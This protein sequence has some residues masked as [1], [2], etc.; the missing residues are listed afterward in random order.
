MSFT[1][2][3]Y[4]ILGFFYIVIIVIANYAISA[5]AQ[6]QENAGNQNQEIKLF[7]DWSNFSFLDLQ[8]VM[9][10]GEIPEK[11]NNKVGWQI[12]RQWQA[13]D[14]VEDVL[15]I[16]DLQNSLAPQL[17]SLKQIYNRIQQS[18]NSNSA[19]SENL[20][21]V[22]AELTLADFAPVGEQ[23]LKSLVDAVRGLGDYTPQEVEPISDLLEA[24]GYDS[25]D[26]DLKTLVSNNGSIAQLKMSSLDLE[27]YSVN[28]IPNLSDTQME[29]FS[30]YQDSYISEIPGLSELSFSQ[31]PNPVSAEINF[32][33]RI[34]LIWGQAESNRV[35]TIS[36]SLIEGFHVPC[37]NNCAYLELDDLENF[38]SKIT[39]DF[40]GNQWIRGK[41]HWVAGGTGCFSG[42]REPTGIHPFGDTFKTVLWETHES[43]DTAEIVMFFN[44]KT[45]CG[46]SPYSIGP[47]PYPQGIV[48][49]NDWVFLG[50]GL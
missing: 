21:L 44:V 28:S 46:E 17:L 4:K 12:S 2:H 13:G 47:F 19:N 16:G 42:G 14:E 7:T 40:E 23:T 24:N 25:F 49:V 41:D 10:S 26:T 43:S 38:G 22:P 31:F 11:L 5:S 6:T 29:D 1:K 39:S 33:G 32:V 27:N 9:E 35:D 3:E 8:P 30:N 34:D 50:S 15:K 18:Q 37:E 48:K 45:N 20:D 36:G